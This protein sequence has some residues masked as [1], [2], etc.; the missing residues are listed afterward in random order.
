MAAGNVEAIRDWAKANF[1]TKD[2]VAKM[3]IDEELPS[4]LIDTISV[5][6]EIIASAYPITLEA[7]SFY[8]F[9][10]P[11]IDS[12]F[13]NAKIIGGNNKLIYQ[14]GIG[15]T[16]YL[17]RALTDSVTYKRAQTGYH[18]SF[19]KINPN[20]IEFDCLAFSSSVA[21][22]SCEEDELYLIVS[23]ADSALAYDGI[24]TG[25]TEIGYLLTDVGSS[26][27]K[28]RVSLVKTT[29]NTLTYSGGNFYYMKLNG[30]Y[31]YSIF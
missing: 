5:G 15:R 16:V 23:N 28:N 31:Q 22:L 30:V 8:I 25:G 20:T 6:T 11:L 26:A 21:S 1:Y 19:M 12:T 7:G 29:G 10:T 27:N 13:T 14:G 24:F 2:E 4:G 3:F 9:T 17:I 18:S